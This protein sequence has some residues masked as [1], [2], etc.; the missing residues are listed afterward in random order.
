MIVVETPRLLLRHLTWDDVDDMAR[1]YADPVVMKFY[2]STRTYEETKQKFELTIGSY[3]KHGFGLW[4]TI[5]KA[6]N[7]FI[8]RCGLI[9][10]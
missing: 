7:K 8:G 3:E 4:A 10:Q 2:P 5:H 6:D 9:A 1:I